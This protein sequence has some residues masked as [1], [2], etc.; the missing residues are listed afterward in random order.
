MKIFIPH[1]LKIRVKN[2]NIFF[3]LPIV[4][5]GRTQSNVQAKGIGS[6]KKYAPTG[7]RTQGKCLEGIY[8]TTTPSALIGRCALEMSM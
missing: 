4:W 2:D 3:H 6:N 7:N 8:V 5:Y 1:V